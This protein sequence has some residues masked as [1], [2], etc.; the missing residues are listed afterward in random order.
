MEFKLLFTLLSPTAL[1]LI[2]VLILQEM[3]YKSL[4]KGQFYMGRKCIDLSAKIFKWTFYYTFLA[5][6]TWSAIQGT[7]E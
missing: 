2:A 5:L 6:V 1:G 7:R 3:A 4:D